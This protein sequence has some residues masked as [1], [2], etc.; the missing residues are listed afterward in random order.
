MWM[1]MD[2]LFELAHALLGLNPYVLL[3]LIIVLAFVA[4]K[5]FA[6]V[7]RVLLTGL[8]FGLFPVVANFLG[9]AIPLTLESV[10]WSAIA[11]IVFYF[12][13][14]GIKFGYGVINAAL[15]PFRK[16]F[17]SRSEKKKVKKAAKKMNEKEKA[18]KSGKAGKS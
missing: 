5:V 2:F 13:Y 4:Y 9:I 11:G 3:G 8:A 10:L 15:W 17:E 6:F 12:V 18:A 1:A 7:F 16:G 14:S